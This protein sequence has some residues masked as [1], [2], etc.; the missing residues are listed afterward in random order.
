MVPT[1]PGAAAEPRSL[2]REVERE[3]RQQGM[4]TLQV[5]LDD[6]RHHPDGTVRVTQQRLAALTGISRGRVQYILRAQTRTA[7]PLEDLERLAA[8]LGLEMVQVQNAA[9]QVYGWNLYATRT[10]KMQRLVASTSRLTEHQLDA[11]QALVDAL[12]TDPAAGE[13]DPPEAATA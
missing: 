10:D 6:A 8:A 7:P 4:N 12:A 2:R 11:V 1:E 13:A 3:D 5:L 9:G